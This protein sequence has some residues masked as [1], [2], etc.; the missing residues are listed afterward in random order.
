[1]ECRSVTFSA[2]LCSVSP[3]SSSVSPS[4]SQDGSSP[5]LL[6]VMPLVIKYVFKVYPLFQ[7]LIVNSTVPPTMLLLAQ[8]SSNLSIPLLT[9]ENPRSWMFTTSRAR[10]LLL[11]CIIPMMFVFLLPLVAIYADFGLLV[12]PRLCSLF[13]QDGAPK[14]DASGMFFK[15]RHTN[16]FLNLLL[17]VHV[18]QEHHLEEVRWPLQGYLPR[19]L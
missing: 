14:E 8:A 19:D 11:L 5:S 13:L 9:A 2:E 1:M 4:P 17:L 18:H 16:S 3:L 6:A 12:Y 15:L 7:T 10:V